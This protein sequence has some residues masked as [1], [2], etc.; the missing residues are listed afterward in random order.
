MFE[1]FEPGSLIADV[2]LI[3]ITSEHP[4]SF[5]NPSHTQLKIANPL[6]VSQTM[7]SS[8]YIS[9]LVNE[10]TCTKEKVKL[11]L[12]LITESLMPDFEKCK[13]DAQSLIIFCAVSS[14]DMGKCQ[15][16]HD[17][18]DSSCNNSGEKK[19]TRCIDMWQLS[20]QPPPLHHG[21]QSLIEDLTCIEI[22]ITIAIKVFSTPSRYKKR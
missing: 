9:Y 8:S 10:N 2:I 13:N 15:P 21:L 18:S 14:M 7:S 3:A 4:T 5:I 16:S 17:G 20:S 1:I 11:E 12:S 19:C 6:V 22:L